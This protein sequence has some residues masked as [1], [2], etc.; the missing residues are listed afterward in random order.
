MQSPDTSDPSD[1]YQSVFLS[2]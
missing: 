1:S 2:I